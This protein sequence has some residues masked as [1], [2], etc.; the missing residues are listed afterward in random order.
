MTRP[1]VVV[2]GATGGIGSAVAHRLIRAEYDILAVATDAGRLQAL[3]ETDMSHI[4][5]MA[6][7]VCVSQSV[8]LTSLITTLDYYGLPSTIAGLVCAH[9]HVPVTTPSLLLSMADEFIPVVLTDIAGTFLSAQAVAPYMLQQQA[10]SMVFIA[11]L[12]AR[13]TYPARAAYAAAKAGIAGMARSLALEWGGAGITVNTLLPWQ[14]A[15]ARSFLLAHKHEQATGEDLLAQYQNRSP[16][17]RLVTE[18]EVADAALFLLQN[19]ACNGM[20]LVLD[21][22]VS[23]S[24]WYKDFS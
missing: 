21:G 2:T 12:H 5:P 24:M 7:N 6:L 18:E 16:Q 8:W 22:G 3:Q 15:G 17:R 9:G 20:E 19:R 10:G 23:A 13:Q 14:V 11:S 4:F 1:L